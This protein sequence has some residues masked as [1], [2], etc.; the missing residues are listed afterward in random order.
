MKRLKVA[1]GVACLFFVLLFGWAISLNFKLHSDWPLALCCGWLTGISCFLFI[2]RNRAFSKNARGTFLVNLGLCVVFLIV[3]GLP[4]FIK[5]R[6]TSCCNACVNN[7]RQIDAAANQFALEHGLTNGSPINFPN[8]L[9]PYMKLNS[10][11]R[12]P[13]CPQGGIYT[14]KKVGDSP[15][16]SLGTT[17]NPAHCLQ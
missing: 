12:I 17:V 11:G 2:Y 7:L 16:C 9:T 3:S 1:I 14:F 8:D 5:A 13:G 10:L 15:V 6:A 4:N